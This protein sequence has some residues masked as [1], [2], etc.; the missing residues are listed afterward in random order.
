MNEFVNSQ[1]MVVFSLPYNL[2][3]EMLNLIPK[4]RLRVDQMMKS[5]HLLSYTLAGDRSVLWAIFAAES[6]SAVE[7][8]IKKL[9][10]TPF[11]QYTIQELMFHMM[12]SQLPSF[13]VN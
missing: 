3:N 10:M 12:P 2:T 8:H 13:S 6:E 9:P 4:Q 11:F 1:Y 7:K 5:G